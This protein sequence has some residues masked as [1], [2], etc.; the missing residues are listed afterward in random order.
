MSK[1][2][3]SFNVGDYVFAKVKGYPPWPAKITSIDKKKYK[4]F[5]YGTGETANLKLED[6]FHYLETKAKYSNVKRPNF[7]IAIDQIEEAINTGED[8]ATLAMDTPIPSSAIDSSSA[9]ITLPAGNETEETA[10]E[11]SKP[12]EAPKGS[13]K[14]KSDPKAKSTPKSTPSTPKAAA[15]KVARKLSVEKVSEPAVA[16]PASEEP[17]TSRS[18]RTIKPKRYLH[19]DFVDE[20]IPPKRKTIDP[21]YPPKEKKP[22]G[23][24][25]EDAA[26]E[27]EE[28]RNIMEE[29]R[30]F[31]SVN[32][33]DSLLTVEKSDTSHNESK[34]TTLD[35]GP[36][37]IKETQNLQTVSVKSD[38]ED[39]ET[40]DL[41]LANTPDGDFVGIRVKYGMP[42][43]FDDEEN[44]QNWLK[45]AVKRS[46]ELKKDI[47]SHTKSIENLKD[48]IDTNLSHP[49]IQNLIDKRR[50]DS[51]RERKVLLESNLLEHDHMIKS[52]IQLTSADVDRAVEL[53]SSYSELKF[54]KFML[55]K[56][57][58]VVETIKKLRRYVGNTK[59]WGFT[60]EQKVQFDEKA[61]K[62]RNLAESIYSVFKSLFDVPEGRAFLDIFNEEVRLLKEKVGHMTPEELLYYDESEDDE[63]IP[64]DDDGNIARKSPSLSATA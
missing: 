40:S 15:S 31:A 61:A 59:N 43:S 16:T 17:V 23:T 33:N 30:E 20:P 13:A 24:V 12:K 10:K 51:E 34:S 25:K 9:D 11:A 2:V 1:K 62:V 54:T 41:L 44:R 8:I 47:E 4:V 3:K 26:T 50:A 37:A 49:F 38:T 19:E 48:E 55:K 56:H 14:I 21:I 32:S 53:M 45:Q 42:Q 63:N 5:F 57:P 7:Q 22:D 60:E 6:C 46:I 27:I 35:V 58:I 36:E 64:D 29:E 52:C 28:E 18:G 39:I